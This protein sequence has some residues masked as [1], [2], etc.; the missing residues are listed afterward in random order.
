MHVFTPGMN[1]VTH[2]VTRGLAR[3]EGCELRETFRGFSQWVAFEN[4]LVNGL[5]ELGRRE[6]APSD[7]SVEIQ[8]VT[9]L[10]VEML[11][12]PYVRPMS[13]TLSS[14]MQQPLESKEASLQAPE[15]YSDDSS[16]TSGRMA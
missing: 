11:R 12:T 4:S 13:E 5:R 10:H 14:P 15:I 9:F 2:N 3:L 8:M 7:G 6:A 1:N 16:A